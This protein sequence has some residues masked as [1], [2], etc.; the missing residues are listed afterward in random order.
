MNG[1]TSIECDFS[2]RELPTYP[3]NT[4]ISARPFP[5]HG[6]KEHHIYLTGHIESIIPIVLSKLLLKTV[7]AIRSLPC[8]NGI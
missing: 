4:S 7:P 3:P 1:R 5:E 8:L 6:L 2:P